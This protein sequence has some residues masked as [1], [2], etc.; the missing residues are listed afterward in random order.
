MLKDENKHHHYYKLIKG[1]KNFDEYIEWRIDKDLHLQKDFFYD[2]NGTCLI[3]FIGKFENLHL[4]FNNVCK[5]LN[6]N[7]AIPHLNKSREN[8]T[9]YID[10]YSKNSIKIVSEAFK[11]DIELFGYTSPQLG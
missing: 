4:D 8:N 7:K 2:E 3:D 10:F 1:M 5:R 11:E 6:V 9:N